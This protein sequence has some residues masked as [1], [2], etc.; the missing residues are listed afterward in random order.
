VGIK[1]QIIST[2]DCQREEVHVPEWDC[3]FYIRSITAQEIDA[4]QCETLTYDKDRNVVI[5][6]QNVRS[7]L[8]VRC[9]VDEAGQR[10]FADNEALLLGSKNNK[11]VERL[12]KIAERLNAVT[13]ED[14]KELSKNS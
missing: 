4:W 12:Y 13:E 9:M 5:N 6:R 3:T 10:I 2:A 7:R 8:L 1:D 11:V 14:I